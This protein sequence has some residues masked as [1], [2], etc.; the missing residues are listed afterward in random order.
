MPPH[1][2]QT[3]CAVLRQAG[4]PRVVHS[5]RS[6]WRIPPRTSFSEAKSH[7]F[8]TRNQSRHIF[9]RRSPRIT[10]RF[11]S[12]SFLVLGLSHSSGS[13]VESGANGAIAPEKVLLQS[14]SDPLSRKYVGEAFRSHAKRCFHTTRRRHAGEGKSKNAIPPQSSEASQA[15]RETPARKSEFHAESEKVKSETPMSEA[16]P[17]PDAHRHEHHITNRALRDRLPHFHRPT[18]EELLA[19]ATGFWSRMRVRFKW[20]SIRSVRPFTLDEIS[21]LFSWVF[22]GHVI[23]FIVGTTTFFS[24]LIFAINTVFAQGK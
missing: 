13:A 24:L 5:L 2:G 8:F 18:K 7:G 23:W 12:G 20:F 21:A 16:S 9:D 3:L 22:L 10:R 17:K 11:A 4:G 19:A 14:W 1:L 15:S 6:S